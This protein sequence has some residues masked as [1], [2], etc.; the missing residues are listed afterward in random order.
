MTLSHPEQEHLF[1]ELDEILSVAEDGLIE[2][3]LDD[4]RF[5][6]I[7]ERLLVVRAEYESAR[8]HRLARA[9]I[10][11]GDESPLATFRSASWYEEA[12]EFELRA[13]APFAPRR[14][15][16][17]GAG[18]FP[19]TAI[20]FMRAH[21]DALVACME[22]VSQACA[23]ASDVARICGCERLQVIHA[24]ALE[25]SE[26]AHYDCVIVGTVVG[27]TDTQKAR[28]VDHF[29]SRVPASTLL[30]FRTAIG[31]G[32]VIYPTV[33]SDILSAT[34]HHVIVDPPQK[35]FTMIITDRGNPSA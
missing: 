7:R 30:I 18:P 9:I 22:R 23:L 26:F 20:S 16:I 14:L 17:V 33:G 25:V 24:E 3:V 5:R 13:L 35:T 10:E 31:P 27:V 29:V 15:L 28:I 34:K 4:A 21:P 2:A 19:T 32:R 8:E 11:A 6:R 12:H 1:T